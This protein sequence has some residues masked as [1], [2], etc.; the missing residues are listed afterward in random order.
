MDRKMKR[1]VFDIITLGCKVNQSESA[2]IGAGLEARGARRWNGKADESGAVSLCIINTCTVTEKASMQSRQAIRR[3]I[4]N[5]PGAR[6]VVTGCYAQTQPAEIEKIAGIH[7]ILG[8]AEKERLAERLLPCPSQLA[9]APADP[10]PAS[11]S[12]P[13]QAGAPMRNDAPACTNRTRAFLKIQDG[14]NARCSYCIVPLAR[15][16]SRSL[17]PALVFD[18]LQ[19]LEDQGHKEVVLSG[20]HLG[21]YGRDLTPGTSLE[22]LLLELERSEGRARLRLSSIEPAEF[23]DPLIELMATSK[24]ICPHAHIPLQSGDDGILK[25][26]GRPYT[27]AFFRDRVIRIHE[28]MPDAAIG[29]DVLVGFPGETD[30]A[31]QATYELVRSLPIS[32]LHVFPFSP[33]QRTPAARFPDRVPTDRVKDRCQRMR[34]LGSE[35]RAQFHARLT[36]RKVAVLVEGKRDGKSG[37]LKGTTATYVPVWLSGADALKNTIVAVLVEKS[38][39]PR[40]VLGHR[41]PCEPQRM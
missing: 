25:K 3:A 8:H 31:F 12:N 39:G 16:A 37:L 19:K 11:V 35:K 38:L 36:G 20:I 15:G 10:E 28:R 26:M 40:G 17:P 14:C 2:S 7:D 30:G 29:I 22:A 6:I 9:M 13:S 18:S 33:R 1:P 34:D 23:T 4:R 5:H 41:L 32:Y 27:A 24:R 21:C